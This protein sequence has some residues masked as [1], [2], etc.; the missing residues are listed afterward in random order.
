MAAATQQLIHA[1][2]A[3]GLA[4][5]I[6]KMSE[7]TR[8]DKRRPIHVEEPNPPVSPPRLTRSRSSFFR[9]RSATGKVVRHAKKLQGGDH[10]QPPRPSRLWSNDDEEQPDEPEDEVTLSAGLLDAFERLRSRI[11]ATFRS[12][13]ESHT[14]SLRTSE[15]VTV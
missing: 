2:R 4:T 5:V 10:T 14:D 1:W 15:A 13:K 3:A 12:G 9:R 6:A 8:G 11:S 7:A